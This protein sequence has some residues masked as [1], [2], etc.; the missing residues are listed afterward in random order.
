MGEGKVATAVRCTFNELMKS[1]MFLSFSK[2]CRIVLKESPYVSQTHLYIMSKPQSTGFRLDLIDSFVFFTKGFHPMQDQ[3]CSHLKSLQATVLWDTG[4]WGLDEA[5][6]PKIPLLKIPDFLPFQVIRKLIMGHPQ[7]QK[8]LWRY[9]LELFVL[10]WTVCKNGSMTWNLS[11][12]GVD[13]RKLVRNIMP[14]IQRFAASQQREHVLVLPFLLVELALAII[15][16][17]WKEVLWRTGGGSLVDRKH[18]FIRVNKS[19]HCIQVFRHLLQIASVRVLVWKHTCPATQKF[20]LLQEGIQSG[21]GLSKLV[22]TDSLLGGN[23]KGTH[24]LREK[25]DWRECP[26]FWDEEGWLSSPY[27]RREASCCRSWNH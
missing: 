8:I 3:S 22:D 19:I 21:R 16:W 5:T 2:C 17:I 13:C 27:S 10:T 18:K 23:P 11:G 26:S 12:R 1:S 14:Q 4:T 20:M 7:S 25:S 24:F 9:H 15:A 6:L